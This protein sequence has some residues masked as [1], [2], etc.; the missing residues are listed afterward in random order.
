LDGLS[1]KK[2]NAGVHVTKKSL[3]WVRGGQRKLLKWRWEECTEVTLQK[4]VYTQNIRPRGPKGIAGG[5]AEGEMGEQ[6][7]YKNWWRGNM[8]NGCQK[9]QRTTAGRNSYKITCSG[10]TREPTNKAKRGERFKTK[11]DH[12]W[13]GDQLCQQ[14][15]SPETG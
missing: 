14:G 6:A 1:T 4:T 11:G 13:R 3:G 5:L 15:K 12:E 7:E 9:S 10:V 2:K 8:L